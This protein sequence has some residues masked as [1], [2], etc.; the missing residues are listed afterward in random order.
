MSIC[1]L[2]DTEI[3][4]ITGFKI[5]PESLDP[6]DYDELME[7][8]PKQIGQL[9]ALQKLVNL[10]TEILAKVDIYLNEKGIDAKNVQLRD[11][12][13]GSVEQI[14]D[15][16][17]FYAGNLDYSEYEKLHENVTKLPDNLKFIFGK[18]Y[19]N[20]TSLESLNLEF[21]NGNTLLYKNPNITTVNVAVV[22]KMFLVSECK[23]LLNISVQDVKDSVRIYSN[24][25]LITANIGNIGSDL[26]VDTS[27]GLSSLSFGNV[28]GKA[29][30][31]H[32]YRLEQLTMGTVKS[33]FT[34]S[35]CDKIQLQNIHS[36]NR[37]KIAINGNFV[38]KI[39]N[40][41]DIKD[42]DVNEK[43]DIKGRF[44]RE[45][46]QYNVW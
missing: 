44:V 33:D 38:L 34:I 37:E 9:E 12:L 1:Q 36:L 20:T 16:T 10:N 25:K 39:P 43:F 24:P 2:I 11:L 26:N 31:G 4:K 17:I 22:M 6:R 19:A 5:N 41:E 8:L 45:T 46:I 28:N 35:R 40:V 27:H 13:A 21:V 18:F 3:K 29:S 7:S 42:K 14:C 32:L 15:T 23:S 30:L